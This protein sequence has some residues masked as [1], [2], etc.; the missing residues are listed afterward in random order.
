MYDA[1]LVAT[2]GS[3]GVSKA[4]EEAID[5]ASLADARLHSLYVIDTRH[6]STL[7]DTAW[8]TLEEAMEEEGE[9]AV[10]A[11]RERAEAANVPVSTAVARGV[12]HE[13]ILAY[14]DE[15]EV[16]LVVMG[17]HGRSGLDHILL[18][19][20]TEKVIRRADMPVLVVRID[21]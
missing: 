17:T 8:F 6:Y 15:A 19:S 3:A 18:G 10:D 20:V 7:P 2:D 1:V 9:A 14:A 12:P 16:D 21:D 11:V 5:I 13:E 4:I